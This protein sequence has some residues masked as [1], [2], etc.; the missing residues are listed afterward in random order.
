MVRMFAAESHAQRSL[1]TSSDETDRLEAFTTT[2]PWLN[3]LFDLPA[4]GRA[5]R[6]S[7]AAFR[8][9]SPDPEEKLLS[10]IRCW[11]GPPRFGYLMATTHWL[12]WVQTAPSRIDEFWSYGYPIEYKRG[13]IGKAF[14]ATS[15]GNQFQTA[16][17][18]PNEAKNFYELYRVAIQ[19]ASWQQSNEVHASVE[20][21]AP[22][23]AATEDLAGQITRLSELMEKGLLSED[24]YLAA[25][26]KLLGI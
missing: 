23:H 22:S 25:K 8:N 21:P 11:H 16:G 9:V 1:S 7:L 14:F 24:E 19:A 15:D 10:A 3:R 20:S 6:G 4:F 18:M 13:G 17:A 12:R 2:N 26:R 5:P